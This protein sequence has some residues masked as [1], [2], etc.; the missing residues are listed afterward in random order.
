MSEIEIDVEFSDDAGRVLASVFL[1]QAYVR[2]LDLNELGKL[3]R[4]I[5]LILG[6]S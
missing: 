2:K 5:Q 6:L 3:I 1:H 4:E